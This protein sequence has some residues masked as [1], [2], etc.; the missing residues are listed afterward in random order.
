MK[1]QYD[2]QL[3]KFA[4]DFNLRRYIQVPNAH[5]IDAAVVN[6][7]RQDSFRHQ[8]VMPLSITVGMKRAG[9]YTRPLFSST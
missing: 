7:S 1:L 8:F 4:F 2:E 3:S 5:F 6:V 9:A